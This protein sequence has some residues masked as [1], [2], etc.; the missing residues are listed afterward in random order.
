MS[1]Q[2]DYSKK[3]T[4]RLWVN[5]ARFLDE[6]LAKLPPDGRGRPQTGRYLSELLLAEQKRKKPKAEPE[7]KEEAAKRKLREDME[8]ME[9]E[10][11]VRDLERKWEDV[12]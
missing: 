1:R 11:L 12:E 9:R 4:C 3:Y 5:A 7:S 8:R 2:R 10:D 6:Q